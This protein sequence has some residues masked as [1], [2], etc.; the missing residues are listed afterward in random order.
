M[1]SLRT[2]ARSAPRTLARASSSLSS[3]TPSTLLRATRSTP[4]AGRTQQISAFSTTMLRAA[5][6]GEVD[7][8]V[9]EKL[10][11]EIQFE[12]EVR[13]NEPQPPSIKDFLENSKFTLEDVPGKED[14]F[15]TRVFGN[16]K[17]V[18]FFFSPVFKQGPSFDL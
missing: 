13:D 10:A 5:K 12:T 8:E 18:F 6:K 15:L 1:M 17:C 4:F 2:I 14:V 16:E 3:R 11:T 7:A 9:S